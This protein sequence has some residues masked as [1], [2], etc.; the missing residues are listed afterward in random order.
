MKGFL[1]SKPVL[2][3]A[4]LLIIA[5]VVISF[6][7]TGT[8][9]THAA[10][11][12]LSNVHPVGGLDCNGYSATGQQSFLSPAFCAD[13]KGVNGERAEDNGH[14]VGHDEPFVGFNST[15]PG[16]GNNIRYTLTLPSERP[17]PATQT[18][19]NQIT[20][21]LSMA[22]CDPQSSPQGACTPDSDTNNPN[23]AGS[24]I[25][26]MQFYPP[27]FAPR[28]VTDVS[29]DTTRWCAALTIDSLSLNPSC[30]EPANFAFIQ[31]NGIPTGPPGPTTMNAATFTPDAQTLLMGQLVRS[32][33]DWGSVALSR[34]YA[35]SSKPEWLRK[36]SC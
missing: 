8:M 30:D 28:N 33:A 10:S 32:E 35:L 21:W 34:V 17:L 12:H 29:C 16:S 14:Y 31:M 6:A 24:A 3:M 5:A 18:F 15:T 25:L 36:N 23:V 27:G 9:R 22:L 20:F 13:P 7:A 26:E 2:G 4:T 11:S 1:R 19:E